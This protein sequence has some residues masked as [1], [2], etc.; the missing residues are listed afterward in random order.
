MYQMS[1]HDYLKN[2][3]LIQNIPKAWKAQLVSENSI[4]PEK[5]A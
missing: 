2:N 4:Q 5:N 3:S 1:Q